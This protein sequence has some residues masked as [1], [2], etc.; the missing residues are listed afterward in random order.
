MDMLSKL[1]GIV[2]GLAK[3]P[4]GLSSA[5]SGIVS[6]AALAAGVLA[7]G[8]FVKSQI[9]ETAT[10]NANMRCEVRIATIQSTQSTEAETRVETA[11]D[12]AEAVAPADTRVVLERVC[13]GDPACRD[14]PN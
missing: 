4:V 10:A 14:R 2:G 9:A 8:W 13:K 11:D 12:A 3:L 5:F 7:I 1:A 6:V